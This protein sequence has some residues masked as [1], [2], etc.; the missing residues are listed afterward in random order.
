[1]RYL[2]RPVFWPLARHAWPAL[3]LLWAAAVQALPAPVLV[4]PS[5]S[6]APPGTV[7]NVNNVLNTLAVDATNRGN[8][9]RWEVAVGVTT[10]AP[11]PPA[12][13]PADIPAAVPALTFNYLTGTEIPGYAGGLNSTQ[14]K[15]T[16]GYYPYPAQQPVYQAPYPQAYPQAYPYPAPVYQS[17]PAPVYVQPAPRYVSPVGVSLSIGGRI[18]RH[19]GVGVG[20]GY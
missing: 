13:Q 9:P 14:S 11:A 7:N 6:P 1:M 5:V 19:A 12:P 18:G 10:P 4:C 2:S 3:A 16:V 17:Y 20:F 8:Q 15:T